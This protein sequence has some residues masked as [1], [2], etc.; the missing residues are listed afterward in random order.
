MIDLQL[1]LRSRPAGL[2]DVPALMCAQVWIHAGP[3]VRVECKD[4]RYVETR[5]DISV[6]PAGWADTWHE[7]ATNTS[8]V[9][10]LSADLLE[11]TASTLG[12]CGVA[13]EPRHVFKDPLIEHLAWA[14]EADGAAGHVA[15]ELYTE[16]LGVALA[17]RVLAGSAPQPRTRAGLSSA[18]LAR[19]TE[20]IE[21]HLDQRLSLARIARVA[22]MSESNLKTMFKRATGLPVHVYVVRRRVERARLLLLEGRAPASQI[23]LDAGFTHQS[24]MARCMKRVLGVTPSALARTTRQ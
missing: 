5:G 10:E 20:Y 3:P 18:E 11:R 8:L 14:L 4:H 13:V 6:L 16:S 15:G 22:G 9:V 21:E 23:A 17:T 2:V 7:G 12:L 1:E 19:L 24:H